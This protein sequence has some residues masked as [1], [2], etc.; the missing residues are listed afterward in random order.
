[1]DKH[2]HH[3]SHNLLLQT[4]KTLENFVREHDGTQAPFLNG[5]VAF[6]E[7]GD[8]QKAYKI[9]KTAHFGAYGFNDWFPP[10]AFEREDADYVQVVFESLTERW[11]RHMRT[12][13]GEAT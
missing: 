5:I 1:M 8:F 2:Y 6:L 12:A 3:V 13:G 10:A 4:T 7:A 9:F 11:A